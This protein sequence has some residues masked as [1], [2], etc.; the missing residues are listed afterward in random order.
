MDN[1][2]LRRITVIHATEEQRQHQTIYKI[3]IDT[4]VIIIYVLL[5]IEAAAAETT[6]SPDENNNIP[7]FFVFEPT[8]PVLHTTITRLCSAQQQNS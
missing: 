5:F 8:L 6:T 1:D 2:W 7:T 4:T 3:W